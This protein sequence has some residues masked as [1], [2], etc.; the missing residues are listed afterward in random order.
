MGGEFSS[1]IVSGVFTCEW[2]G[3]SL[4]FIHPRAAETEVLVHAEQ[5]QNSAEQ[6]RTREE[7]AILGPGEQ[8][9]SKG[10]SG[11]LKAPTNTTT[12]HKKPKICDITFWKN[13]PLRDSVAVG[14]RA[15]RSV[16]MQGRAGSVQACGRHWQA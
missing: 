8:F 3:L 14:R 7:H 4:R 16:T 9:S 15:G 1:E 12:Q 6:R 10:V 2:A 13:T 11:P 5:A